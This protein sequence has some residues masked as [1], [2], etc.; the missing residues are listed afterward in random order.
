MKHLTAGGTDQ[1]A[2]HHVATIDTGC[3]ARQP[4]SR[5]FGRHLYESRHDG[6]Q[7]PPP[8]LLAI[9]AGTGVLALLLFALASIGALRPAWIIASTGLAVAWAGYVAW[10]HAS[11]GAA[12][13]RAWP[14]EPWLRA[15]AGLLALTLL[16]IVY[17]MVEGISK[18][19][20]ALTIRPLPNWGWLLASGLLGVALSFYLWADMP[21][22]AAW[23]TAIS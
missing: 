6:F 10:N 23:R 13:S 19:V 5:L 9:P 18:I 8:R 12:R 11:E 22:T 14:T 15:A 2:G 1:Y 21:V 3:V 17:F 7:H 4:L 16:V 20:L